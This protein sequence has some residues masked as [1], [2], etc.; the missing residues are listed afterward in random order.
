[1][2]TKYLREI[3]KAIKIR[4]I[5]R[6]DVSLRDI[7]QIL[8]EE[9]VSKAMFD[10][11]NDLDFDRIEYNIRC[12]TD[13]IIKIFYDTTFLYEIVLNRST[14]FIIFTFDSPCEYLLY[15][16]ISMKQIIRELK[17]KNILNEEK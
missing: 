10:F 7:I 4:K 1:M 15:K 3:L 17:L 5:D 14:Y 11:E 2:R 16:T 12:N 13:E 8:S 9:I 6:D